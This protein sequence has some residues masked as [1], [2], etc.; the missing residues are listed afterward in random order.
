MP[1]VNDNNNQVVVTEVV[2]DVVVSS[3]GPQGPRGKTILNGEGVPA[4]NLGL[5][6][7]FYYDKLTT[8]FYGPKPNDLT[9]AGA[10]SSYIPLCYKSSSFLS[11]RGCRKSDTILVSNNQP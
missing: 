10:N 4:E 5:E 6:G 2:N 8:K 11:R 7:D 3:L 9:W 1:I